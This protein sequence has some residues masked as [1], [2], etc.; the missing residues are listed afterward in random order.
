MWSL[1]IYPILSKPRTNLIYLG[2]DLSYQK[3]KTDVCHFECNFPI[4]DNE[5]KTRRVKGKEP[6]KWQSSIVYSNN[7]FS[8][9]Q[10]QNREKACHISKQECYTI[11]TDSKGK[12]KTPPS[13]PQKK[14]TKCHS[15]TDQ[16]R[17]P[18]YI[19]KWFLS[20]TLCSKF[21]VYPNYL[22]KA[23]QFYTIFQPYPYLFRFSTIPFLIWLLN[24]IFCC[25][26]QLISC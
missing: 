12:G 20:V 5:P 23:L 2:D 13:P 18:W 19:V 24:I 22:D 7:F 17:E 8:N 1:L 26:P 15:R 11:I 9:Y 3:N 6:A 25:G 4:D 21:K 10:Y 14:T 16:Q